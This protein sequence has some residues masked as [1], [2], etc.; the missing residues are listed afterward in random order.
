MVTIFIWV[1]TVQQTGNRWHI[2]NLIL[3]VYLWEDPEGSGGE[4]GGRGDGEY[5]YIQGRFMSMY[6]KNHHNIVK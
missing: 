6:D 1:G 2:S 3:I 4:G 5:M